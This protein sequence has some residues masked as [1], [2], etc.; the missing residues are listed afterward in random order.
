M[1]GM[2]P[3][4]IREI[5]ELAECGKRMHD[6]VSQV[7][8]D[9]IPFE[10]KHCWLAFRLEDGKWSGALYDSLPAAKKHTDQW[11]HCYMAM[12]GVLG[13]ISAKD[14]EI[15]LDVHRQARPVNIA[16]SDPDRSLIMPFP[17]GDVFRA[18]QQGDLLWYASRIR[19]AISSTCR[20]PHGTGL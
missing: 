7:L 2:K 20:Q 18:A 5:A 12:M 11:T 13:G 3:K 6:V 17:A 15:F 1:A 14:C 9:F 4:S 10:I 16:Q 8:T 19:K